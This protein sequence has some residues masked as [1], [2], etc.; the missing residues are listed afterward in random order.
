MVVCL[1]LAE[2]G[3]YQSHWVTLALGGRPADAAFQ[4]LAARNWVD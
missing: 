2:V 3:S 4:G 1:I